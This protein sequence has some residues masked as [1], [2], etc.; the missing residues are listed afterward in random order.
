MLAFAPLDAAVGVASTAVGTLATGLAPLAGGAATAAAIVGFTVAVRLLITPLTVA[1]VRGERRR[2]ALAPQLAELRRRYGDDP[3]RLQRELA[4]LYRTAG[5]GPL[6]GCLPALLQAPFF[7]VMYRLFSVG[8]RAALAGE[9]VGVPLAH[10]L[11]DGVAGAAGPLFGVLLLGLLGLARLSSRRMRR[12]MAAGSA[13]LTGSAGSGVGPGAV[14]DVGAVAGR[15]LPL[16]PYATLPVALLVPLAGVL[17][18]VTT[19]AWTALEHAVLR[20]DRSISPP[21]LDRNS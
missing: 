3:A 12:T 17:Y 18:L 15:I 21:A 7:L 4:G 2:A 6:A 1:Q 14:G 9:L 16:L 5:A 13:G 11:T 8:D 20:R 19:T 10:H